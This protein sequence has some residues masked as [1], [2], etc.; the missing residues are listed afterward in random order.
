MKLS[1]AIFCSLL[2]LMTGNIAFSQ[3][4]DS[5][6]WKNRLVLLVVNNEKAPQLKE[7]LE[8]FQ[9]DPAGLKER[10]LEIITI[11]PNAFKTGNNA[12]VGDTR[13]YE[14]YHRKKDFELVLIGL[15]GGEKLRK[16]EPIHL[17]ELFRL[18]DSM[19]MRAAEIRRN[20]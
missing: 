6:R 4:L 2:L 9:E 12:W 18:I 17:A 8:L 19:P 16:P 3:N 5:Y 20:N 11:R 15:D 13:L 10:K 1:K 7:Q 14:R